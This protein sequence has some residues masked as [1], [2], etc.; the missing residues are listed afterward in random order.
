MII[1]TPRD[2]PGFRELLGDGSDYGIALS[3]AEQMEPNGLAEAFIIGREFVGTDTVAMILGDN[4]FYG[5]GI[6]QMCT[7]AAKLKKGASI[8]A[9][10]VE[11]PERY[12]VVEFDPQSKKALTIEEKPEDPRSSW[13]VTGLYFYD[14]DVLD[15]ARNIEP[16]ARGELEITA[17]NNVYLERDDLHVHQLGRGFAWLDTGT[18]DSL[19]EA[20]SFVRAIEHR[21]GIKMACLEEIG[22]AKGWLDAGDV[23][24]RAGQ[25][26]KAPYA[27]YLKRI[28]GEL[29]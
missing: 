2:L 1:S 23:L 8:F 21:Q 12:G 25:W 18:H 17:V 9:Y 19:H 26:G 7:Q 5:D 28:V 3:Y 15:I 22:L 13:A 24:R 10:R 16:S 11:D 4:I 27:D 20:S 14:N 29:S 6:S